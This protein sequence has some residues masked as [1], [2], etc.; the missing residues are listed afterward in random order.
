MR[1]RIYTH[2]GFVAHPLPDNS[3]LL[4]YPYLGAETIDLDDIAKGSHPDTAPAATRLV[5][6]EI[7]DGVPVHFEVTPGNHDSRIATVDS[8]TL[9]HGTVLAFG[10]GYRLSFCRGL[11]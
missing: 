2:S 1:V 6:V 4:T 11:E 3:H 8:P 7:T 9:I 10:A 5:R